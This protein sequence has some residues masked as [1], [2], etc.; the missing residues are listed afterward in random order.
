MTRNVKENLQEKMEMSVKKRTFCS[1]FAMPQPSVAVVAWLAERRFIELWGNEE[2]GVIG[3]I[4]L[5]F[6]KIPKK[7]CFF[8]CNSQHRFA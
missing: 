1:I 3:G 4:I 6:T 5:N 2:L 7:Y 8:S